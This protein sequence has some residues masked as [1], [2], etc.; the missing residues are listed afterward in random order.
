MA[1]EHLHGTFKS[2]KATV[3]TTRITRPHNT[4]R[5]I[6]C[7]K[8]SLAWLCKAVSSLVFKHYSFSKSVVQ[9]SA[10]SIQHLLILAMICLSPIMLGQASCAP[11][12]SQLQVTSWCQ[13]AYSMQ[14]AR[15]FSLDNHLYR[16]DTTPSTFTA[17]RT[18]SKFKT[19]KN[20]IHKMLLGILALITK[21]VRFLSV[22][23]F[24]L[25]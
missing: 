9:H 8:Y 1:V 6:S 13:W 4:A 16:G 3:K 24:S 14:A 25:E 21:F 5:D 19:V 7:V 15:V 11:K 17:F 22:F 23:H 12:H 10:S 20:P 18:V 2:A